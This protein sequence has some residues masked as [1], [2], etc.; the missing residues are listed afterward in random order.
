MKFTSYGV[1]TFLLTASLS[2]ADNV[3]VRKAQAGVGKPGNSEAPQDCLLVEMEKMYMEGGNHETEWYCM[4]SDSTSYKIEGI[5]AS[6]LATRGIASGLYRM[7][8]SNA[9]KSNDRS[10][11]KMKVQA[12][13]K[14]DFYLD[15]RKGQMKKDQ[16]HRKLAPY[17]GESSMLVIRVV[18]SV[19]GSSPSKSAPELA[20]DVFGIGMFDQHNLASQIEACSGG[21]FTYVPAAGTGIVNGVLDVT[22]DVDLAGMDSGTAVNYAVGAAQAQVGVLTQWTQHM[23]VLPSNVNF[24]GAAAWAYINGV[25]SAYLNQYASHVVVQ[26]HEI[27]HNLGLYHSGEGSATYL[28]HTCN[29]GNPGYT[30]EGPTLCFNGQKSWYLGWYEDRHHTVT[31]ETNSWVGKIAGIDDYLNGQT[32]NEKVVVKIDNMLSSTDLYVM[33]NRKEGVNSGVVDYP[34]EVVIVEGSVGNVASQSWLLGHLSASQVYRSSNWESNGKDLV[35]EV[36]EMVTGVPDYA[37]VMIYLDEGSVN[38]PSCV[39]STPAPIP[40][41]PAPIPPTPAPIPPTPAPI[42]PTPAPIPPTPAPI[43]PTPAPI[44]PTPA[45]IPPTPAP[46]P[47]TPAPIPG[48]CLDLK[49]ELKTDSYGYETSWQ[50]KEKNGVVLEKNR[51]SYSSNTEYTEHLGCR[52]IGDNE[53]ERYEFTIH[54]SYGDGICCAYGAGSYKL[55]ANEKILKK[56]GAFSS[57]ES[58]KFPVDPKTIPNFKLELRTDFW[59]YESSWT[60]KDA[61]GSQLYSGSGYSSSTTYLVDIMLPLDKCYTFT[62][63]DSYGDGIYY[64]YYKVYWKGD[65][66]MY[67]PGNFGYESGGTFGNCQNAYMVPIVPGDVALRD[68]P[69]GGNGKNKG[70]GNDNNGKSNKGNN[71]Y[72]NKFENGK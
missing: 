41:T 38:N 22:V 35:V 40:P 62:M 44:P 30:D 32:T 46:I 31:P 20:S 67:V 27:G 50:L 52:P 68:P 12:N 59:G 51:I 34:N 66:V 60:I 23:V 36:C 25:Q 72:G 39:V 45:P 33:Y 2:F 61:N 11:P 9:S 71:K 4:D 14:L 55:T 8:A 21:K 47:P 6:D 24:G 54:D 49:L 64:G 7:K 65:Q 19:D 26:I 15:K 53:Y 10:G 57:S 1:L 63:K 37:R 69:L 17:A 70:K 5:S 42:P 43:P 13:A 28:D 48:S 58:F 18:S 16:S 3:R 56:G 29:M